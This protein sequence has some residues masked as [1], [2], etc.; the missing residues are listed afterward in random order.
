MEIKELF[1]SME[2]G[3][4]PENHQFAQE[5]LDKWNSK[6]K[7]YINGEWREAKSGEYVN[8]MN[9]AT[10]TV[11]TQVSKAGKEDLEDAVK[12]A[13][14]AQKKWFNIGG[15]SRARYIYAIARHIQKHAR[16]FSVLETMNNGKP[17][18]ET[19]DID[20][21]LVA[22]HFYYHAGWAQLM[23][24]ELADYEPVGV[25]GQIIPWN[26]PLL[27]MAWKIAPAIA[28]GNT[29]ILKP[30]SY[31]PVTAILFAEI[32][33]EV[34]L[35]PGVVN[36]VTGPSAI[37]KEIVC[38]PDISKIAFTGS[39]EVGRWIRNASAGSGKKISLE[40][41]GKSPFIVFED[42]DL[43][44]AIEGV[45]DAIWF[46]QGQVCCAGS[47][48][49][50]QES[51]AENFINKL[52]IR[53]EKLRVGNPLDK[54]VDMGA[55]VSPQQ[56]KT[57]SDFV[58]IGAKEG[59][60]IIQPSWKLP[61]DGYFFYPTLVTNLEP[62]STIVQEEIFGPVLVSLTFRTPK[63]AV[64]LANNTVFGLAASLWSEDINLA[65]DIAPQIKA[66]SVWINCTN[67]F[68]A[69][70]GFGGYKESGYGREGG[71]EGLFEY[72]KRKTSKSKNGN[73]FSKLASQGDVKPST[74]HIPQINRTPKLYI[75]GKQVRPDATYV[76][77]IKNPSGEVVGEVGR[78]NR[79]DV[80]NA[81]DIAR[82]SLS[83]WSSKSGH[84]RAQVLYYIAENLNIR[85]DEFVDR[86]KY[87]VGYSQ[88]Q[89]EIEFDT[90]VQV[91][92]AYA[93]WA[94][95]YDGLVHST[96]SRHVTLA[97]NEPIGNMAV[98]CPNEHP[99]LSFISSI[100]PPIAMGN[101][102][103]VVPSEQYPLLATDF[104][105]IL[106][107]SDVPGGVVNIITGYYDELITFLA[108]HHDID[109]I[110]YFGS[111]E[112]SQQVELESCSNMK[113]TWVSNGK[114]VDW[115]DFTRQRDFLRECTQVKNIWIPYGV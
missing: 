105:Q 83:G 21:P 50:V 2:Y 32:C 100:M 12:S 43:D 19:R 17:I 57:I 68:D 115:F 55:I 90:S 22:R 112:G 80:R 81:V 78:G 92:F 94:D 82:K 61:S 74:N 75:G 99:L 93:S 34:G 103:T 52:K 42:A 10:G 29:V 70:S 28:M 66:G 33:H 77:H 31:T 36:I 65:L 38:H 30:A 104:Y 47:R 13:I 7:L 111:K 59:G 23:E 67:M 107:T 113:R 51:I 73:K 40:L 16:L 3:P 106:E 46:N 24:T 64:A 71:K 49:I 84:N 9:P 91:I 108:S 45:V 4:A 39:T 5:W 69:G 114:T 58:K 97:M 8:A 54:A 76:I 62:S 14:M 53:M 63:E 20:I 85:R 87:I 101:V 86:L 41:G 35:P 88:A 89:A 60:N 15:H 110:W 44:S 27:M 48:L 109:S 18:R 79:K 72:V 25:V 26:F 37:G 1:D 6:L 98:I 102:I 95:K 56:L 11:L 96:L